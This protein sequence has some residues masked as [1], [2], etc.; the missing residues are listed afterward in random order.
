MAVENNVKLGQQ[1]GIYRLDALLGEGGMGSVY[2]AYDLNLQRKVALKLMLPR[3]ARNEAF[4]ARFLQEARAAARLDHPS[5]IRILHFESLPDLLYLVMAY[6][7]GPNLRRYVSHRVEGNAPLPLAEILGLTAQVADALGYAHQQGIVHRDIKPDNL[8]LQ[9]VSSQTASGEPELRVIV[10]DFGL[11]KLQYGGIQT[12]TGTFMG[13]LP[14]MSPE[15]CK[16]QELDGRSDLY[17]LGVVL[18]QLVTGRLPFDVSSPTEALYNHVNVAPPVPAQLRPGLPGAVNELLLRSLAKE[19]ENRYLNGEEMAVALRAAAVELG[20]WDETTLTPL[21]Q[22]MTPVPPSGVTRTGGVNLSQAAQA[23]NSAAITDPRRFDHLLL[24]KPGENTRAVPLGRERLLIGRG[25]NCDV[26]LDDELVSTEHCRLQ[27]SE[28]GWQVVD[29]NSKNGTF[30]QGNRLL[31]GVAEP[32]EPGQTLR[33]GRHSLQW[34]PAQGGQSS[35]VM[36][37]MGSLGGTMLRTT[38][39]DIG[40]TVEPAQL[41]L[42]RGE[43]AV[44]QVGIQNLGQR[45]AH[46]RLTQSGLAPAWTQL[47]EDSVQLMPGA[48]SYISIT[49]QLPKDETSASGTLPFKIEA[50]S[51]ASGAL[52]ASVPCELLVRAERGMNVAMQPTQL[53]VGQTGRIALQN[54]GNAP[55]TYK[56]RGQDSAGALNFD[57]SQTEATL[58]P[59][60]K[61]LV[62]VQTAVKKRPWVGAAQ[63]VPF[64]ID[65][66]ATDAPSDVRQLSGLA[67]IKPRL[68]AWLVPLLGVALLLLCGLS[69]G[70]AYA[71]FGRPDPT[72]TQIAIVPPEPEPTATPERLPTDEPGTTPVATES[73]QTA[74]SEPAATNEPTATATIAPTATLIPSP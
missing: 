40:L 65:V 63:M 45:V 17:S 19:P 53:A 67:T 36:S 30:L 2:Q 25:E 24:A 54:S 41:S 47:S 35:A 42:G 58:Q 15:Q 13:T 73:A 27:K 49:I 10:T 4:R 20:D 18:Y 60:E 8:L 28:R 39:A 59:G 64:T 5:I 61:Q 50:Q 56:M 68:P 1:I 12:Q 48:E 21:P 33:V 16:G 9:P 23:L 71:I 32:W 70:G 22:S 31:A 69:A 51:P 3:L 74:T 43:K 11:A 66:F 26:R 38:L 55:T 6:V 72:A 14:Y 46:F 34:R 29:L 7:S 57:F 37:Q 62:T 44:L 52:R